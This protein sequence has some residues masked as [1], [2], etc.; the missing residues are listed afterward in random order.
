MLDYAANAVAYWPIE[1]IQAMLESNCTKN[2]TDS[3]QVLD[4][5]LEGESAGDEFWENTKPV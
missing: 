1:S 4:E 3:V 2:G 5:F